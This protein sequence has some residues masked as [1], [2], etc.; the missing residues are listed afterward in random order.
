L[1]NGNYMILGKKTTS[2]DHTLFRALYKYISLIHHKK[3]KPLPDIFY[4]ENKIVK[5]LYVLINNCQ[6]CGK[7]TS[8]E[9]KH[10]MC[11]ALMLNTEDKFSL[12]E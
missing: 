6:K 8:S 7:G 1:Q 2:S 4:I 5:L 12:R 11:T 9:R 3:F 10:R